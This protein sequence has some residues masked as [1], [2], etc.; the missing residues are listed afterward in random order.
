MSAVGMAPLPLAALD[1]LDVAI[2]VIDLDATIAYANPAAQL[3]VGSDVRLAEANVLELL[4]KIGAP[5]SEITSTLRADRSWSGRIEIPHR[6]GSSATVRARA[7]PIREG[8][9][10]VGTLGLMEPPT[11]ELGE[12][13]LADRV[14]DLARVVAEVAAAEDLAEVAQI[15]IDNAVSVLGARSSF[16]GTLEGDDTLWAAGTQLG[17]WQRIPLREDY[18]IT[19]AIR[20]H[21]IVTAVSGEELDRRW[22]GLFPAGEHSLIVVPLLVPRGCIGVLSLD[23]AVAREL[24]EWER[25]YLVAL[26]DTC[27]QAVERVSARSEAADADAKLAFL[28]GASEALAASLDY[29]ATLRTVADLAVPRLADWC[30]IDLLEDGRLRRVAV[31][32]VDP[33]KVNYAW[34]LWERFPPDLNAPTGAPAVLRTGVSELVEA[35]DDE[36]LDALGLDEEIRRLVREL[37]LNSG[38][39]VALQARGRTLGVLSLVYAESGRHF[40]QDDIRF[41]EDLARRAAMAIDNAELHT[42]TLQV[43]LQLQRAVLPE[44]F[45]EMP[46]WRV[47]VHYRP[48]GRSEVGGDFFDA[49]P[50]PDGRIVALVGDVMGRGVAAAAAMAQARAAVRAYLVED[51]EPE[52]VLARLD[53]MFAALEVSQLV[54]LL[55]CLLDPSSGEGRWHS[56]GHLPPIVLHAD[57]TAERLAVPTT[58]PLGAGTFARRSSVFPFAATDTLVLYSDGLVERRG[59]D[60]DEGLARLLGACPHLAGRLSDAALAELADELRQAGHDDDVTI[61][62][63]QSRSALRR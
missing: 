8:E 30:T 38:L 17:R 9:R 10:R 44:T 3:L 35:V 1:A 12:I 20:T 6:D 22:P 56:A 24:F 47:A 59:E 39:T 62:A 51:P 40:R 31:S 48:A 19:E 27:A 46:A 45:A 32:H 58:P 15:V 36:L 53:Q 14:V 49:H 29:E 41:A 57:G 26:A 60:I 4:A 25:R 34:E 11:S 55:Y 61:L 37:Q 42:E 16:F 50:L 52:A 43:A 5:I 33:A 18:P 63:L 13:L 54:T 23:F 7:V 28:A 21:R 2:V